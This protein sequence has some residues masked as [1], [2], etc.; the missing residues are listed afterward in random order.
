M[1]K[2]VTQCSVL[3]W[4]TIC[5]KSSFKWM[6]SKYHLSL[7][8]HTRERKKVVKIFLKF[9]TFSV[10]FLWMTF[11]WPPSPWHA[12]YCHLF[13]VILKTWPL[14]LNLAGLHSPSARSWD[15]RADKGLLAQ[16]RQGAPSH[17]H[18]RL[19]TLP[20]CRGSFPFFCVCF[21]V[22]GPQALL[23]PLWIKTRSQPQS[24]NNTVYSGTP[25]PVT[26]FHYCESD[27]I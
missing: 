22:L 4:N 7:W 17:P 26:N 10:Q 21:Y 13:S 19:T 5:W 25:W 3:C 18:C 23:P 27:W 24:E 14:T 9:L 20:L 2:L 1:N 8:A 6:R 15:R 16:P 11:R 12:Q